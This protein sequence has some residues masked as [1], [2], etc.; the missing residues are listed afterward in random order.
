MNDKIVKASN[1]IKSNLLNILPY[2]LGPISL[3]K[4]KRISIELSKNEII[5]CNLQSKKKEITKLIKEKFEFVKL[6][7]TFE[8]EYQKYVDHII[9]IVKREKLEKKEVN[10]LIPSPEV[11]L[12]TI[13]MPLTSDNEL[14]QQLRTQDFWSQFTDL[15]AEGIKEMLN[16]L[17]LSYQILSKNKKENT[18]EILFAYVD[19]E[20]NE[21]KN[22]ILKSSGLNPTVF[23]PK[24]L[25]ITNL[26]ML[27]Q[28]MKKNDE[29]LLLVYGESENY[30]IHRTE[31]KFSFIENKLTRSDITL[32]KQLEKMSDGSG[33][34]W[35]ELYDR[36]L[37]NI[38]PSIEEIIEN[39]ENKIKELFIFSE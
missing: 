25:A 31:N 23:E 17:A 18:M 34:F 36:F 12:K 27:T 15:P 28:K 22:Q 13:T 10:L 32:L 26:I 38:K 7:T 33:P 19:T 3:A 39:P 1:Q 14:S 4:E 20:G 2:I 21:I 9:E 8:K 5:F 11:T 35:D 29:F 37:S 16:G 6:D 30:L 24:C